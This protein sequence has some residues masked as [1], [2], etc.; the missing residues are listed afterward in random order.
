MGDT[1]AFNVQ[2]GSEGRPHMPSP[3][4]KCCTEDPGDVPVDIT[5]V[6]LSPLPAGPVEPGTVSELLAIGWASQPAFD[7]DEACMASNSQEK[8]ADATGMERR[9][10]E[11][12][13]LDE[14]VET[15]S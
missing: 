1:I 7:S 12:D 15:D 4:W 11:D 2:I 8:Q 9:Q 3:C 14:F 10:A 6:E 5:S 13:R